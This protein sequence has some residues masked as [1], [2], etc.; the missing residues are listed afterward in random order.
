MKAKYIAAALALGFFACTE[1]SDT[2]PTG[3]T[4]TSAKAELGTALHGTVTQTRAMNAA[5]PTLT[6]TADRTAHKLTIK[7]G[8]SSGLYAYSSGSWAING[9]GVKFPDNAA[10]DVALTLAPEVENPVSKQD[11]TVAAL[12]DADILVG[13]L[14]SQAP[15]NELPAVTLTHA[16]TLLDFTIDGLTAAVLDTYTIT[17]NEVIIPCRVP[18]GGTK[19]QA[20]VEPGG[21]V[22]N[23]FLGVGTDKFTAL[24]GSAEGT[25]Q[26]NTRYT[27]KIILES[28]GIRIE[29]VAVSQWDEKDP[30]SGTAV[31]N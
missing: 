25:F 8:E 11:G 2:E 22:A 19:M 28:A 30:G 9:V 29:N 4:V 10:A 20:I 23:I 6:P 5:D 24:V 26:P 17:I 15:V 12:I 27:F 21:N 14:K 1:P 16:N 13:E 31:L 18:M 7:I 3:T